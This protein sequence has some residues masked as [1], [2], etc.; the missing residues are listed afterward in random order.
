LIT[1]EEGKEKAKLI[2]AKAR[3]GYHPVTSATIDEMLK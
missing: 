1:T 3:E 2:Y